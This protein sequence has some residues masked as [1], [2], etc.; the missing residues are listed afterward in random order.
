M[1]EKEVDAYNAE[2]AERRRIKREEFKAKYGMTIIEADLGN[3]PAA[4]YNNGSGNW[5][6]D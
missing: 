2:R 6:G 1:T 5:T 3:G 4:D